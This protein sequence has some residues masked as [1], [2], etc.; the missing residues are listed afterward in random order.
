M[1]IVFVVG[2][3]LTEQ[4]R[5]SVTNLKGI[6]VL[7]F[8]IS[9]TTLEF[10]ES[11]GVS[12]PFTFA[13]LLPIQSSMV[14]EPRE[15]VTFLSVASHPTVPPRDSIIARIGRRV[16]LFLM[17]GGESKVLEMPFIVNEV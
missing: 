17:T 15:T 12:T 5:F 13:V 14:V 3:Q 8:I 6:I 1:V 7:E 9:G 10:D 11:I 4:P 16:R 2:S